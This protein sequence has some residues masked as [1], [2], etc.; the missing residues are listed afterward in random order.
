MKHK[1]SFDEIKKKNGD[2]RT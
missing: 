2:E 1:L